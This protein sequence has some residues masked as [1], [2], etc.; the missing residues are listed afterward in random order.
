MKS[1]KKVRENVQYTGKV[2]EFL[3]RKKVGTLSQS[4]LRGY[5]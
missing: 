2:R 3:G 1:G 5:K 4:S